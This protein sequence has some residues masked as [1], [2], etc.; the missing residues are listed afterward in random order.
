M[1]EKIRTII[2]K[3]RLEKALL[4]TT[5]KTPSVITDQDANFSV[6]NKKAVLSLVQIT[7]QEDMNVDAFK[8]DKL[9]V[10]INEDT[11]LAFRDDYILHAINFEVMNN[12]GVIYSFSSN[13]LKI[14]E[15]NIDRKILHDTTRNEPCMQKS[16]GDIYSPSHRTAE[17]ADI[18]AL[19]LAWN[20]TNHLFGYSLKKDGR[21]SFYLILNEE[22]DANVTAENFI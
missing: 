21:I 2:D 10:N 15:Y 11:E 5:A 6:F 20:K 4:S 7:Y 18:E 22:L 17:N 9:Y 1:L 3:K 19:R 12:K 14:A 13:G 8:L 16:N